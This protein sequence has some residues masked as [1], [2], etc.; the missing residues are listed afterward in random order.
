MTPDEL[1]Q[2]RKPDWERLSALLQRA[3]HGQLAAMNEAELIEFGRLYRATTSDLAIAQRDFPRHNLAVYLNQLVGRA[4]PF[5]YHGEPVIWRRLREFYLRGF[6]QLYREVAPFIGLA[7]LLFLGTGVVFYL[8]TL[9]N[10]DAASYVLSPRLVGYIKSGHLWFKD[11]GAGGE[12]LAALIMT[13]NIQVAFF[14]FAGGMALSLITIYVL[15]SNGLALGA[16]LALMQVYG[17]AAPLW[18]FV[19]GHGVLELSEL[20]MAGGSGLMLGYA[21]LQPGLLSRRNALS[22]AARK[23]V[24]LLLGS[25]PLLVIA[26]I[27]EG[28][29]SPSDAPF[30]LKYA[31]GITSGILLY[32]YLF[33]ASYSPP[34]L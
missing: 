12:T 26:G 20:T 10:P 28:L 5:I 4:H 3:Q 23:S 2:N 16:V 8:V 6:P 18:E 11:P 22:E 19:I 27:I 14:A 30:W 7:A 25:V 24:K 21:V 17:H 34:R 33:R 29:L 31:V 15:I 1:I 9:A 32:A 13:N